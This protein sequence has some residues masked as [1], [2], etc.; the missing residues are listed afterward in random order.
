MSSELRKPFSV[1]ILVGNTSTDRADLDAVTEQARSAIVKAAPVG[2]TF[3]MFLAARNG[4]IGLALWNAWAV[5]DDSGMLHSLFVAPA[6]STV[7]V[8]DWTDELMALESFP[9]PA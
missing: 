4:Q 5:A 8:R 2:M 6:E 1:D 9:A 3:A 7:A